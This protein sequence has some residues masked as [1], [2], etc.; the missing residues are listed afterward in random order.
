MGAAGLQHVLWASAGIA[1][2]GYAALWHAV[3]VLREPVLRRVRLEIPMKLFRAVGTRPSG[4]LYLGE[5]MRLRKVS[6]ILS[7]KLSLQALKLL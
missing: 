5:P 4:I 3:A 6:R 7:M 1:D 2:D